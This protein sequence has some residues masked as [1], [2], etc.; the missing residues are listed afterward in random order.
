MEYI[1]CNRDF[2]TNSG[3]YDLKGSEYSTFLGICAR[4]SSVFSFR[5]YEGITSERWKQVL[6]SFQIA[7]PKWA[8]VE[9]DTFP[10]SERKWFWCNTESVV[11]LQSLE[12]NLFNMK[13]LHGLT[14]PEDIVFYREN[15]SIFAY[16]ETD[17]GEC[18]VYPEIEEDISEL[19]R[20][21]HWF[22]YD[23]KKHWEKD[24]EVLETLA[25]LSQRYLEK[26]DRS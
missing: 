13:T 6:G 12:D 22:E 21:P 8:D 3:E 20:N 24:Y 5:I 26:Q 17:E 23:S 1:C 9:E 2:Y 14:N 25:V 18:I 10:I 11:A 16:A 4:Y 15:G 19:I 7:E